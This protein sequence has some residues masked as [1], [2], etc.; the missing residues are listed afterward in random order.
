VQREVLS[1]SREKLAALEA[2]VRELESAL[3]KAG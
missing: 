1:R 2:R 3:A